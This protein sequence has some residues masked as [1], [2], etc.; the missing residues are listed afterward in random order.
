MPAGR[1]NACSASSAL[2]QAKQNSAGGVEALKASVAPGPAPVKSE[3]ALRFALTG[4]TRG[5][6]LS[7]SV[8]AYGKETYRSQSGLPGLVH[9]GNPPRIMTRPRSALDR[10]IAA[11]TSA[12]VGSAPG[13][14]PRIT[15]TCPSRVARIARSTAATRLSNWFTACGPP[16]CSRGRQRASVGRQAPPQSP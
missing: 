10:E 5:R 9:S 1:S 11:A 7:S 14:P 2:P 12:S 15:M 16:E 3:T 6:P 4:G 8:F 13:M